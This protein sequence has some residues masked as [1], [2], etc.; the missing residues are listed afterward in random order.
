M[1]YIFKANI[2]YIL[3]LK[4]LKLLLFVNIIFDAC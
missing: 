3:A 1:L 4:T 2:Q